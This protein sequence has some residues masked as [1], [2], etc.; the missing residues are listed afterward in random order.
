MNQDRFSELIKSFL[1][2]NFPEFTNNISNKDDTSFD[3]DL[4][5]PTNEFSI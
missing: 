4:R 3:C 1:I 5:N 2:E